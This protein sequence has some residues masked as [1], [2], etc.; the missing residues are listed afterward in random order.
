MVEGEEFSVQC[1]E[2]G[3]RR[4]DLQPHNRDPDL[5]LSPFP[6]FLIPNS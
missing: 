2:R 6:Q 5:D 1:A 4:A 3:E